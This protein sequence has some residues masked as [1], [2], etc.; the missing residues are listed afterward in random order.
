[1]N[2]YEADVSPTRVTV[3]ANE[4]AAYPTYL[5]KLALPLSNQFIYIFILYFT[6]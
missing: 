3:P 2:T 5:L 6:T 4:E 1:M